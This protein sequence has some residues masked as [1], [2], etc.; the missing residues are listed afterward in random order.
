MD[1]IHAGSSLAQYIFLARTAAPEPVLYAAA[2]LLAS[3][4]INLPHLRRLVGF[5]IFY[6]RCSVAFCGQMHKIF[7]C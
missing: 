1:G 7:A 2:L 5:C 6:I 3:V 4:K